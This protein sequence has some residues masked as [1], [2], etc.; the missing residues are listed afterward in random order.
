MSKMQVLQQYSRGYG[1]R[2]E[3]ED[4]ERYDHCPTMP[5]PRLYNNPS[6]IQMSGSCKNK[7]DQWDQFAQKPGVAYMKSMS[8]NTARVG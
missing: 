3:Q 6:D 1:V 7:A 8:R 4:G 2:I 5:V